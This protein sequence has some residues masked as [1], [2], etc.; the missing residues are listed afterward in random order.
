MTRKIFVLGA[1]GT[2]RSIMGSIPE[3]QDAVFLDDHI[4]PGRINNRDHLGPL[5]ILDGVADALVIV[6]F[7]CTYME[8]RKE[9]FLR[10]SRKFGMAT[11]IDPSSSVDRS[12]T[13]GDGTWLGPNTTVMPNAT[14]GK[15]IVVCANASIDHDCKV[16]DHAYIS[17]GVHLA[18]AA[19]MG[20]GVFI[21]TGANILPCVEIG[22]W[23]TVG[24]GAVVTRNVEPRCTVAGVPARVA[25]KGEV[26]K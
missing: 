4:A 21:G 11:V 14:V 15:D 5:S 7:G 17:P 24:A 2:G 22:E 20:E 13:I 3:D 19:K 1:G 23:A 18:G 8:A 16:G 12:A 6:G 25:K 9:T 26:T 10:L